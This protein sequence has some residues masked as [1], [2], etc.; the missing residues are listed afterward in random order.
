MSVSVII[1][2]YQAPRELDFA[3]CAISR[4]SVMPDEVLV[5]DDGSDEETR[6]LVNSWMDELPCRLI[7]CWQ[8]DKGYRKARIV[9]EAVRRSTGSHLIFLDG[10]SFPHL[11]WVADHLRAHAEGR[12]LC[13]RRV[14]LGLEFSG[15]LTRDRILAGEF[16]RIG[17]A[18]LTSA[19]RGDTKRLSLGIRIPQLL[20]RLFHPSARRLMGVNFGLGRKEF[21]AVNGL[22]ERWATYGREDYDLELRLR[23]AGYEF[24]PLLN[25]GI[26]YHIY[27]IERERSEEALA[28]TAI[29]EASREIRCEFGVESEL[30]FD[31]QQ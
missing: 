28:L 18:L 21:Y 12:I 31:S 25:R 13:G 30:A 7:H 5:A 4:Q 24:Y 10:D 22:N 14:K 3:L 11:H 2:T 17:A 29:Q 15:E 9:N 6:L 27:H 19:L 1:C 8:A 20:V 16:D 26:V 23:R